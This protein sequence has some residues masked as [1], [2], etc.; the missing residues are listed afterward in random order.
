MKLRAFVKAEGG[1]AAVIVA[2]SLTILL[3]FTALT[4]D[5]GLLASTRQSMQNAVD[6]AALAAAMDVGKHRSYDEIYAT[7]K[8]Y[9]ILNGFDPAQSNVDI[10]VS[11]YGKSVSVQLDC[12]RKMGFSA[13][14]TGRNRRTV[15]ASATAEAVSIFGS[16]PFAMFASQ[17]IQEGGYGMVINGEDI[18]INGNIHSNSDILMR[19]A[20]LGEG[21]VATA[22]RS[23][24]PNTEGWKGNQ[25]AL[26]MPS[27][28]AFEKTIEGRTDIAEF[29]GTIVKNSHSGFGELVDEAITKY[30]GKMGADQGYLTNG[31]Y[32]H[33]KGDLIF[34]GN[35]NVPY[36]ATFPIVL[37]VDGSINMNGMPLDCTIDTPMVIMSKRGMITVNGGGACFTGILYAPKGLVQI[38]G[39]DAEFVGSIIAQNILKNGGKITVRYMEDTDRFLPLSKVHLIE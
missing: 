17:R 27:L 33:V 1:A 13:V 5:F 6:A 8:E 22:V 29:N 16:C 15:A 18:Y 38:N 11:T 9:C 3:G 7:A 20:V 36:R 39:N 19:N 26:D 24:L 35:T 25:I 28:A 34:N 31:L 14:L 2:L 37:I 10:T 4:M 12:E 21:V 23:V 32:I 30:R